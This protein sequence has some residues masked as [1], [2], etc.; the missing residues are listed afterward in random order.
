MHPSNSKSFYALEFTDYVINYDVFANKLEQW[1]LTQD[2]PIYSFVAADILPG[3]NIN[4][5]R[6]IF[7][8]DSKFLR[9]ER[10]KQRS[11]AQNA[12][13][14]SVVRN[15]THQEIPNYSI[16]TIPSKPIKTTKK[17]DFLSKVKDAG[18]VIRRSFNI[19][20]TY[21]S[22]NGSR[23]AK[24][25]ETDNNLIF[26]IKSPNITALRNKMFNKKAKSKVEDTKIEDI[27]T[28]LFEGLVLSD[29]NASLEEV[30][31]EKPKEKVTTEPKFILFPRIIMDGDEKHKSES[32]NETLLKS[33]PVVDDVTIISGK[34]IRDTENLIIPEHGQGEI[35]AINVGTERNKKT[36]YAV[37]RKR[38]SV[39]Q[40]NNVI[41]VSLTQFLSF[42]MRF[43]AF[44]TKEFF[45]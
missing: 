3:L 16:P 21:M 35:I 41:E 13:I 14:L 12:P 24:V 36:L 32:Q 5:G 10:R 26:A 28:S 2:N 40:G 22:P 43:Y 44:L 19:Q 25:N 1:K 33:E 20:S 9:S 11:I 45:R 15:K 18:D 34:G 39:I 23:I 31:T 4:N 7:S 27:D 42:K 17:I 6:K 8:L 38:N 37:T 30:T 29:K